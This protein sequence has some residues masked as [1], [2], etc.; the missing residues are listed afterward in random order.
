LNLP[1]GDDV[2]DAEFDN[3]GCLRPGQHS[4]KIRF[5][6]DLEFPPGSVYSC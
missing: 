6:D 2:V 3:T 1:A 4:R 5:P